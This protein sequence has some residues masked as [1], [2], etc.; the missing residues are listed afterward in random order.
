VED[1]RDEGAFE[2]QNP[3]L[4]T[5]VNIDGVAVVIPS[6]ERAARLAKD[7]TFVATKH[8]HNGRW[9]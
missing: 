6:P 3:L 8:F 5:T 9:S 4:R 2:S 7:G 1:L